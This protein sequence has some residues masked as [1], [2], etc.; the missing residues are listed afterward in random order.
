MIE[1]MVTVFYKYKQCQSFLA[2]IFE[3]IC[4]KTFEKLNTIEKMNENPHLVDD[5]F[6]MLTRY[7]KY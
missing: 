5:F 4:I 1:V 7:L 6:G 3:Q 2:N